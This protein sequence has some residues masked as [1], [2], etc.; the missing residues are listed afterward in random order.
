MTRWQKV[1]AGGILA[2]L[3]L[4]WAPVPT[5]R[6][7]T[8]Y[9]GGFVHQPRRTRDQTPN[10]ASRPST[11]STPQQLPYSYRSYAYPAPPV[12]RPARA[13]AADEEKWAYGVPAS[14]LPWN[15]AGFEGFNEPPATA[16][17]AALGQPTKYALEAAALPPPTTAPNPRVVLLVAHLPE[18]AIL[19]I[20]G[21][22][23]RATG[24]TRYF[25]SPPLEADKKFRYTARA[26][27]CEEGRWV[28]QTRDVPV[29]AGHVAALYL[30]L[31]AEARERSREARIEANLARL[32]P[33]DQK[34]ARMQKICVVRT[35]TRLGEHGV[36][37]KVVVKDRRVFVCSEGCVKKAL[38]HPNRTAAL[39]KALADRHAADTPEK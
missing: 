33:E 2:G 32:D 9:D 35:E 5:C 16:Q 21:Q 14:A 1:L 30:A 10:P 15:R 3:G 38:A 34:A 8:H 37:V 7:E 19:W 39:A 29:Q 17:D 12:A 31:S 36:P 11:S 18:D 24:R 13:P 23:T 20:N 6:A 28:T 22:L 4:L 26:A 25:E 27:W